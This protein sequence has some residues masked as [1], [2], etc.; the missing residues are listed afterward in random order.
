MRAV[1]AFSFSLV[2]ASASAL[3]AAPPGSLLTTVAPGLAFSTGTLQVVPGSS[4]PGQ[5]VPLLVTLQTADDFAVY[6]RHVLSLSIASPLEYA[7]QARVYRVCR[8]AAGG[9]SGGSLDVDCTGS[10]EG[11]GGPRVVRSSLMYALPKQMPKDLAEIALSIQFVDTTTGNVV[12]DL[13]KVVIHI[14]PARIIK[15]LSVSPSV[16]VLGDDMTLVAAG[17]TGGGPGAMFGV[18]TLVKVVVLRPPLIAG[19]WTVYP[20]CDGSGTEVRTDFGVQCPVKAGKDFNGRLAYRPPITQ[21]LLAL[22]GNKVDAVV[23]LSVVHNVTGV[24]MG[25]GVL[26]FSMVA[27]ALQLGLSQMKAAEKAAAGSGSGSGS[28]SGAGSAGEGVFDGGDSK[29]GITALDAG[30]D[31]TAVA[32]SKG[33]Q[34]DK[35]GALI[36]ATEGGKVYSA[37]Q[38]TVPCPDPVSGFEQ[39]FCAH[40]R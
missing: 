37:P 39:L 34:T 36:N 29:D 24:D 28:G 12:Q 23:Y 11:G 31:L 19:Q 38:P 20:L 16:A 6:P 13:G 21:G 17:N 9:A 27:T 7:G 26:R 40:T 32:G 4:V 25:G 5:A 15:S 35:L 14:A 10:R 1:A 2:L 22:N 3:Y 8:G 18:D 33:Q 30:S